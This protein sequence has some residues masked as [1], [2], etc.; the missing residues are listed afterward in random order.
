[1]IPWAFG[2]YGF[3]AEGPTRNCERFDIGGL[4]VGIAH[5]YDLPYLVHREK[6]RFQTKSQMR[7][8]LA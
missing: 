4:L 2:R 5:K 1:M 7:E 3:Q 8:M 6:S